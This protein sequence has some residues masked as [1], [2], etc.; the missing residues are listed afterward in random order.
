VA[1]LAAA[2]CGGAR[3]EVEGVRERDQRRERFGGS[4]FT[5]RKKEKK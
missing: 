4:S 2:S 5:A 1:A 3:V